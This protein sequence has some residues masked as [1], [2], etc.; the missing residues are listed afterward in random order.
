MLFLTSLNI[1]SSIL[2]SYVVMT[3]SIVILTCIL[4]WQC[5]QFFVQNMLWRKMYICCLWFFFYQVWKCELYRFYLENFVYFG[6]GNKYSF[7][8]QF[9][10]ILLYIK[11]FVNYPAT[12]SYCL[13]EAISGLYWS[14]KKRAQY[15][16]M[17]DIY[18]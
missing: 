1:L 12:Y 5:L 3:P 18:M 6:I 9:L 2:A 17:E 7:W 11:S 8:T 13:V 4:M 10:L 16:Q 14:T 15:E